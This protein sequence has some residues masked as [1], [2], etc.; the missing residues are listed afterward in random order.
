[1]YFQGTSL[2]LFCL[3]FMSL[4]LLQLLYVLFSYSCSDMIWY[5]Y[6]YKWL[7]DIDMMLSPIGKQVCYENQS[8]NFNISESSLQILDNLATTCSSVVV[9]VIL[10]NSKHIG[11]PFRENTI[12]YPFSMTYPPSALLTASAFF[13]MSYLTKCLTR[14]FHIFVL[15][16]ILWPQ[17][18]G[19]PYPVIQLAQLC[20][21]EMPTG[22]KVQQH[23]LHTL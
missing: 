20:I 13:S 11:N 4:K 7:Y 17:N 6:D 2:D 23:L 16:K 10:Q 21:Q 14:I 8:K 19:Q 3:N 15:W 12:C 1:M 18:K 5:W 22:I 9:K